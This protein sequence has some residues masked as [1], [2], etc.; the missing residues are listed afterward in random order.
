MKNQS[1]LTRVMRPEGR[2]RRGR[3]RGGGAEGRI[4]VAGKR[5]ALGR[6]ALGMGVNGSGADG[7][8]RNKLQ[9]NPQTE[10]PSITRSLYFRST[11]HVYPQGL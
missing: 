5:R 7:R 3:E 1:V 9:F 8:R 6:I 10:D 2:R 11:I 4:A